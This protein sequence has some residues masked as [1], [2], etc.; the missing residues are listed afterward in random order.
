MK[1]AAK[2]GQTVDVSALIVKYTYA[3]DLNRDGRIDAQ[4][5]GIIDNFAQFPGANSYFNGDIN[6]DGVIDAVDYVIIGNGIQLR[7]PRL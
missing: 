5:C 1:P 2:Q 3:G 6:Y 4:D 7:G